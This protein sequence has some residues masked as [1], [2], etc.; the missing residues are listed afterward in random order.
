MD[1]IFGYLQSGIEK[2]V[3]FIILLGLLI[4]VHELGHFLVAKFWGVR[5]EIFSLGFGKKIL[6][7]KKGDTTYCLSLIIACP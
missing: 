1:I 4:F 3:P 6:K 2:V 7:Y 5:V